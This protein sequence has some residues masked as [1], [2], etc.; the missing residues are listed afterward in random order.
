MNVF[1]KAW[2]TASVS[3]CVHAFVTE[4]KVVQTLPWNYNGWHA[5]GVANKTHIGFEILEPSGFQYKCGT[6][7]IGYDVEKNQTYFNNVYRN[8]VELCAML[9]QEFDLDPMHDIL[10]H[11]EGSKIGIASNHGDVMHWFP[12]HKKDMDQFRSDVKA[13]MDTQKKVA[14]AIVT[15]AVEEGQEEI[16]YKV[17]VT[18]AVLNVRKGAGTSYGI[19]TTVK[20]GDIYTIVET[21]GSWGRL[22]SGAG[23]ISLKS[24]AGWI[25]LKYTEKK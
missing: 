14:K 22:K 18:A 11:S 6:N 24:G 19:A 21:N 17:R 2:N 25:S 1:L 16:G 3:K 7:M 8:A 12:K 20:K 5:E 15:V 13:E 10:C 23:W 9:C 4:D